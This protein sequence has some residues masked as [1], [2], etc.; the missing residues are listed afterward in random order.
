[1][2][3]PNSFAGF[4]AALASANHK[5]AEVRRRFNPR[6]PGVIREGSASAAVLAFLRESGR[7]HTEASIRFVVKRS[8]SATSWAL[9]YLRGQGLIEAVSDARRSGRYLRYRAVPQE[10]GSDD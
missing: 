4:L 9:L 7:F 3:D 5:P 8:H 6:P 10:G 1:M 2:T